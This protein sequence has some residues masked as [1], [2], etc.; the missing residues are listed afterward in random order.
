MPARAHGD[1]IS[2][3]GLVLLLVVVTAVGPFSQNI[4]IPSMPSLQAAFATDYGTAQLALSLFLI[5]AGVGQIAHG[6]LSDRFGRRPVMIGGLLLYAAASV[7]CVV[8]PSILTLVTGRF[9][10]A[11]GGCVGM[12]VGRAM[13]RDL[14]DR[15]RTASVMAYLT[16]AMVLAPM[17]APTIGGFLDVWYGWRATFMLLVGVGAVVVAIVWRW[18]PET[19]APNP[20]THGFRVYGPAVADL[21]RQRRFLGYTFQVSFTTATFFVFQG[22]VPYV[23]VE[24][25][26]RPPSDFGLYIMPVIA[27][28]MAG[29]LVSARLAP[30]LGIDRLI[31]AGVVLC[32]AVALALAGAYLALGA[33][34][35]LLFGGMAV[36]AFGHG[37]CLP[38][39]F[40]GAVTVD[41]K[42]AG[43]A[44][45]IAGAVHMT[46]G[47]AA[48]FLV[49][50][51]VGETALPV[52]VLM[53]T[54]ATVSLVAHFVGVR[55][56]KSGP[57]LP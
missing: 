17:V 12:V 4:F 14:F 15:S 39:G 13:L 26:G 42:L 52:V 29:N 3:R 37:L 49:G 20:D 8:A 2:R 25:L 57:D 31:S 30:R 10:Q 11:V 35:E 5:G 23:M 27:L 55:P 56:G 21:F 50:E 51:I 38:N 41:P 1:P 16:M 36:I 22:G 44:A 34:A 53:A 9:L 24:L 48:S 7:A 19:H 40:A 54:M 47:A 6:P 33:S 28:Y 18:F 46:T 32:L 43:A 45:G